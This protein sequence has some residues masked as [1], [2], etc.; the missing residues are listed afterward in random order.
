VK[1][2]RDLFD[3]GCSKP[4][5]RHLTWKDGAGSWCAMS[6]GQLRHEVAALASGLLR[7][8]LRK[9]DRVALLSRNSPRWAIGDFALVTSG[10]VDVPLYPSLSPEQVRFILDDSGARALL[11]EDAEQRQR[12][13]GILH[14]S[15]IEVVVLMD[16]SAPGPSGVRWCSLIQEGAAPGGPDAPAVEPEDLASIIYTS[17]TTGVPKGVMLSQHNL[18]SNALQCHEAISLSDIDHVNLSLLPLCHIFQRLVD[19]FLFMR[20]ASI[21]Y[22]PNP[23]EGVQV[24][25]EV[26]PTFFAAVPRLYEK[27]HQGFWAKVERSSPLQRAIARWAVRVGKRRFEAWCR[28]GACD[29]VPGPWLELRAAVADRLV[30]RRARA[31]FGGRVDACFSGGAP[32]PTEVAEFLRAIGLPLLPGYGLSEAS[33]VLCTNTKRFLRLG[34]VGKALPGVELEVAED[35]ELLARGPNVMQ[36]YWNRAEETAATLVGGWLRT[37]DLARIDDRGYVSITGRKKEILVL[38]TGKKVVPA[39]VE[40]RLM[41]SPYVHQAVCVG[42]GAKF[43]AA[44]VHANVDLLAAEARRRGVAWAS[45]AELLARREAEQIVLESFEAPAADLSEFERPKAVGFLPRELTQAG[46]ELTPTLKVKRKAITENWGDLIAAVYG[47]PA[48]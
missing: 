36:G 13:E 21:A 17:G 6:T 8:G 22:C 27:V 10:L 1:T 28:D 4:K 43:V 15:S 38:S 31:V 35:G 9:G 5:E 32:I 3:V 45:V 24:M 46:G 11:L 47:R 18:V 7:R 48:P 33:P 37:G 41:R 14:G 23:L 34:T 42:D 2:L 16:D 29:G 20:G 19:Y 39:V 26:R 40:D 25:A 12:L 44:L 30:L